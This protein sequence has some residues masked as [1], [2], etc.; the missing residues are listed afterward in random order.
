M[1]HNRVAE[2]WLTRSGMRL[3]DHLR[4]TVERTEATPERLVLDPKAVADP[5]AEVLLLGCALIAGEAAR[6]GWQRARLEGWHFTRRRIGAALF[7]GQRGTNLTVYATNEY[8]HAADQV[9]ALSLTYCAG[10]PPESIPWEARRYP[11]EVCEARPEE[12]AYALAERIVRLAE[13]RRRL[14]DLGTF[15]REGPATPPAKRLQIVLDEA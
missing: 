4:G 2:V 12:V 1:D 3:W 7:E 6:P 5:R 14:R 9:D 13:A 15:L 11:R 10:Y 8:C